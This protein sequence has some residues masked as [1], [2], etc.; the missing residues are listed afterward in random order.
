MIRRTG[1]KTSVPQI[2]AD[3]VYIGDCDAIHLLEA[4]GELTARLGLGDK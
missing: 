4:N 1:G 2:F 3:D